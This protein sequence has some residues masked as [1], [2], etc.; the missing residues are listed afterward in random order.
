MKKRADVIK[1]YAAIRRTMLESYQSAAEEKYFEPLQEKV[2]ALRGKMKNNAGEKK[3]KNRLTIG[4][5]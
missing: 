4:H 1:K 2:D 5:Q 3:I